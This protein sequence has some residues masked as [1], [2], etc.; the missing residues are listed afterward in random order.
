[1]SA[2]L[3]LAISFLAYFLFSFVFQI[4]AAKKKMLF[5]FLDIY[6]VYIY[7][8]LKPL[9]WNLRDHAF[10]EKVVLCNWCFLLEEIKEIQK[11]DR[12]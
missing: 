11:N 10:L 5:F 8:Y 6:N 1:M 4:E 2:A 7:S 12:R 9:Q 3:S